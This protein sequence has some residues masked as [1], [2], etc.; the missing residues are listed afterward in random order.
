MLEFNIR[1]S[2]K[3]IKLIIAVIIVW[4]KKKILTLITL[5][6]IILQDIK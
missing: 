1:G 5:I 6:T 2:K 3:D 4:N